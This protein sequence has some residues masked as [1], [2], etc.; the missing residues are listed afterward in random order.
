VSSSRQPSALPLPL[1]A[2]ALAPIVIA[3]VGGSL[4][5]GLPYLGFIDFQEQIVPVVVTGG[6]LLPIR[7]V[8]GDEVEEEEWRRYESAPLWADV[9]LETIERLLSGFAM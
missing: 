7:L 3:G 8:K 5:V 6:A 2:P 4:E 1:P 9:A